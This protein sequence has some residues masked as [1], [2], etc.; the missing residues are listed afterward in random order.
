M[1]SDSV[2]HRMMLDRAKELALDTRLAVWQ[3]AARTG[4]EDGAALHKLV[5]RARKGAAR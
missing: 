4:L 3:I 5:R 1:P 2:W